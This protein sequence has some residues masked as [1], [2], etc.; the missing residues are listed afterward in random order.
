M[1]K[2]TSGA[3]AGLIGGML[4][5]VMAGSINYMQMTLFKEEY[6]KM[7]RETLREVINKAG[8]Q[9]P[10]GMS[11]EQL[12]E[13]SYNIGKIWGSIGAMVIFLIIG[14]IAGIVY[15]LVYGKLPTK[16]P[17]FKALIVTLTIYVIWTIISNVFALRIGVSSFRAMPQTFMVIGYVLGFVEYCILGLVIGA[18]HYKWYIRTAE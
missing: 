2:I 11:L 1:G 9:L 6:L 14:V 16:S 7:M 12:V 18:L 10:S 5:G 17:I 15:A 13:L 3:K 4:S 8:G